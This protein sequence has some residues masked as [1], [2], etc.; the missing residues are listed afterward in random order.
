MTPNTFNIFTREEPHD[1]KAGEYHSIAL[2]NKA[3]LVTD[4]RS[5]S[6]QR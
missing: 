3:H 4:R 1:K 6:G 2:F 5:G